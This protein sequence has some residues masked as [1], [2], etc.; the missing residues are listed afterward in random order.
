METFIKEALEQRFGVRRFRYR[1][2]VRRN[3]QAAATDLV[4][5]FREKR[6]SVVSAVEMREHELIEIDQ[7]DQ[8]VAKICSPRPDG[9]LATSHRAGR[10]NS[11]ISVVNSDSQTC[12]SIKL[13]A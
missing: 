11:L 12:T 1:E 4:A 3:R 7:R 13:C 6:A 9:G 2:P 8:A 10:G 5:H